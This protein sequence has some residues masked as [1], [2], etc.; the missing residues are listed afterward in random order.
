[1]TLSRDWIDR[2]QKAQ[3]PIDGWIRGVAYEEWLAPRAGPWTRKD[4][5]G[6]LTAWSDFLLD[7]VDALR[8]N[9]PE[10]IEAVPVDAW[11][12]VEVERRRSWTV[13]ATIGAWRRSARRTEEVVSALSPEAWDGRWRVA[14]AAEP[15]SI[16]DVL[17]L[18]EV[19][20]GQ[21]RSALANDMS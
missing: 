20:L 4:L 16:E 6:H 10:A 19:H 5:L 9:R 12:A 8:Q 18:M 14:W 1:M 21:H 3:E 7:Q 17:R 2:L 11:N 15:V 13:E